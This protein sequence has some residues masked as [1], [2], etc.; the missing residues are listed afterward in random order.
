[1]WPIA[2]STQGWD[3]KALKYQG[4]DIPSPISEMESDGSHATL[5][6]IRYFH[7]LT[8]SAGMPARPTGAALWQEA[9]PLSHH[10]LAQ[11]P[12]ACHLRFL[13]CKW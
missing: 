6:R 9:E 5:E 11:E 12:G 7:I 1:M 2:T 3:H 8:Q 13:I 10:S 4:L